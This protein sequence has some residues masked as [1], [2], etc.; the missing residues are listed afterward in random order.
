MK[1]KF[2]CEKQRWRK[3]AAM[4][5]CGGYCRRSTEM[6]EAL[7]VHTNNSFPPQNV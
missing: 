5:A 3:V 1:Q 2:V 4:A 7:P 6:D